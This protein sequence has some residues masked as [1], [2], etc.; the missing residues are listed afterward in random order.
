[1]TSTTENQLM[2][3]KF[4]KAFR[5]AKQI[6]YSSETVLKFSYEMALRYVNTPDACFVECGC[7]AGA[8][9]IA[10]KAGA[11]FKVVY[12]FDS[13]DGLPLPSNKDNQMPG[14]CMLTE[15]EQRCLPDPGK[16]KLESTGAVRV[17]IESF[18]EHIEKSGVNRVNIIPIK[19]WFEE[20]VPKFVEENPDLQIAILRLDGDLYNSTYVC[21]KHLYPKVIAGGCV[22]IDDIQL[23]GCRQAV[24]DYF[25]EEGITEILR[26][27]DNI[28]YFIKGPSKD[29][30]V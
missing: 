16:Q 12:A 5:Y 27:V 24:K 9:V 28:A 22:I 4:D 15:T 17:A 19:G 11:P 6:A 30:A 21:L 26:Y 3:T 18:H 10:L 7:A 20:T 29:F 13:W 14:L 23:P 2:D 8:Q 1:M 25:E